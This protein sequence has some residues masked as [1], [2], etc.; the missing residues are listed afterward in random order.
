MRF[1]S[2]SREDSVAKKCTDDTF[3]SIHNHFEHVPWGFV[4]AAQRRTK[5]RQH[6]LDLRGSLTLALIRD[7]TPASTPRETGA[8]D[9]GESGHAR[10]GLADRP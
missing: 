8:E 4:A 3:D 6:I 9:V 1:G 2:P 7:R 10:S 5:P